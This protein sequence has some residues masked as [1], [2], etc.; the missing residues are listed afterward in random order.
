MTSSLAATLLKASSAV[1]AAESNCLEALSTAAAT[2][3][4]L[5]ALSILVSAAFLASSIAAKALS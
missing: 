1:A 5:V 2:A 4:A 3:S